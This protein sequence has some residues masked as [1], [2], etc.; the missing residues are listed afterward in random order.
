ML[1]FYCFGIAA[2]VVIDAVAALLHFL[3]LLQGENFIFRFGFYSIFS[4]LFVYPHILLF[5][6]L[7]Y[8]CSFFAHLPF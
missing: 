6:S 2:V 8:F 1:Y 5:V 7:F 3:F 4:A